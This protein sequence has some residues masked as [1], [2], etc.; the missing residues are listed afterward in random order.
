MKIFDAIDKYLYFLKVEKG[1]SLNTISSYEEDIKH[2]LLCIL[3]R[4]GWF[5]IMVDIIFR[6]YFWNILRKNLFGLFEQL[7]DIV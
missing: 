1:L 7:C 2:F 3:F 4:I 6:L 5:K